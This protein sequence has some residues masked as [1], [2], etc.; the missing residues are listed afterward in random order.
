MGKIVRMTSEEIKA[1]RAAGGDMT[2]WER[3]RNLTEEEVDRMAMEDPDN[4][5]KTDE[6]WAQVTV[7][8]PGLRGPQKAP[9]K[10][11]LAIR[12]SPDVVEYFKATG[13]G[14][15]SRIDSALREWMSGHPMKQI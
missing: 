13:A 10:K 4:F 12:L 8:R 14:W 1:M 5:L 3:V 15:Q 11:P 7:H 9:K 6:D 2:K